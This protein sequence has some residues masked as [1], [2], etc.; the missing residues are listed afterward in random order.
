MNDL[1]ANEVRLLMNYFQTSVK[2]LEKRRVGSRIQR[3]YEAP[4][5]PLDRLIAR[6]FI[7]EATAQHLLEHRA[8]LDPVALVASIERKVKAIFA[9]PVGPIVPVR[10]RAD[11][12]EYSWKARQVDRA[13][14]QAPVRSFMAR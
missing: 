9:L 4:M 13:Y 7:D 12:P 6:Q 3:V 14:K 10:R 8:T 2:L 1:Y 11:V 5:T